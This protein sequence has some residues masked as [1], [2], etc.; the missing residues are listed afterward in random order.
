MSA[1]QQREYKYDDREQEYRSN[2]YLRQHS[3]LDDNGGQFPGDG[4]ER[5]GLRVVGMS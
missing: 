3:L 1:K 4:I 5:F 2:P